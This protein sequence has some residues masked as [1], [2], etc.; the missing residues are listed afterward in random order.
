MVGGAVHKEAFRDMA[1]IAELKETYDGEWLAIV[2]T[3]RE[4][5]ESI[6]GELV[7]HSK[8]RDAVWKNVTGDTRTLFVTYAGP[9][10]PP[11]RIAA[12]L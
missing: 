9:P 12:F 8:D 7:F 5:H 1:K 3:K 11:G 4:D 6:E 10:L 2:V